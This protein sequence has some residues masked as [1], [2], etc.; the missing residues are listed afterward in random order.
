MDIGS[1]P[2]GIVD[3]GQYIYILT[4]TRLYVLRA[5]SLHALIDTLD[6]GNPS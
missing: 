5:D 4:G 6:G 2:Q 3:T 1:V